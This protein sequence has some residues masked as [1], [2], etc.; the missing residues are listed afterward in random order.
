MDQ[1]LL[2]I[3]DP[4]LINII[5]SKVDP[6]ILTEIQIFSFPNF[7][8]MTFR[9]DWFSHSLAQF[10]W[11]DKHPNWSI[12][13]SS[14]N[15]YQSWCWAW[16]CSAPACFNNVINLI[17]MMNL[18]NEFHNDMD[19]NL[20]INLFKRLSFTILMNLIIGMNCINVMAI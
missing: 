3:F 8:Q 19:F 7:A 20:T 2:S 4:H 13:S 1:N 11:S 5:W 12:S 16:H 9:L 14:N 17:K 10:L 18:C 15:I 6:C